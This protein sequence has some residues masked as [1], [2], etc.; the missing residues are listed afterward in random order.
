MDIEGLGF[1]GCL[2]LTGIIL[3]CAALVGAVIGL[4]AGC[5]SLVAGWVGG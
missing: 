2:G 3:G 4:V 1:S 5:A